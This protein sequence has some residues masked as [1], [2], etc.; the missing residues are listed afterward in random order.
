MSYSALA[1]HERSSYLMISNLGAEVTALR[2]TVRALDPSFDEV[3]AE[4]RSA[5][6]RTNAPFEA[7]ATG[8]Y[9]ELIDKLK[10]GY[11]C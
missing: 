4:K 2:E 11:V 3:L 1:T 10:A 6:V 7:G 5:E 8:I 9:D